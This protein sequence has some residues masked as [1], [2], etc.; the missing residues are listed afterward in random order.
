ME[1]DRRSRLLNVNSHVFNDRPR[2]FVRFESSAP[3]ISRLANN[4]RNFRIILTGNP[5]RPVYL[6]SAHKLPNAKRKI[7]RFR[8]RATQIHRRIAGIRHNVAADNY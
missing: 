6:L 1:R 2:S 5:A 7:V 4:H 8:G 3:G